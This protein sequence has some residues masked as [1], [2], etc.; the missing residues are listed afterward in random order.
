MDSKIEIETKNL[1]GIPVNIATKLYPN[2]RFIKINGVSQKLT[3]DF[4]DER[5]NVVTENG[6]IIEI[7]N[8]Y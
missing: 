2:I 1:I 7:D 3:K 8:F 5:L 4:V 6:F